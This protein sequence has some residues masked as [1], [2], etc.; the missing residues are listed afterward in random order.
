MRAVREDRRLGKLPAQQRA[1]LVEWL[2]D[3]GLS[4]RR[5]QERLLAEFNVK[6]AHTS[7][8]YF[9]LQHCVPLRLRRAAEAANALPD[10]TGGVMSAWTEGSIAL[11]KQKYFELLAAPSPDPKELALFAS[12]AVH[13]DRERMDREKLRFQRQQAAAALRL[14]R[15]ALELSKWKFQTRVADLALKFAKEIK[16]IAADRS[17][18]AG[19]K[20]REVRQRLFGSAPQAATTS[21]GKP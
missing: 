15:R 12:Q 5:A 19:A 11:V 1:C 13:V 20:I 17:L 21:E 9:Y 7:V 14:K 2:L 10:V 16:S 6:V 3:E 8:Y 18:D 4:Y